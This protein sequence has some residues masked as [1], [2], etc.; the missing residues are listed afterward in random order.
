MSQIVDEINAILLK[1]GIAEVISDRDVTVTD[2]TVS[3]YVKPVHRLSNC[4]TEH[5]WPSVSCATVYHFTSREA[6]E[7]ILNS[8][9]FRFNNIAKRYTEGEVIAFCKSHSLSGYLENG[10][11]GVPRYKTLLMPS[12]F[13]SAFTE[14]TLD[15]EE[16]DY[17]W[18]NF[19]AVDGVRLT[20]QIEASNPNFRRMLY[21]KV[22][23]SPIPVLAELAATILSK[24][25][26][27]LVVSGISRLCAFYL[28]G[29]DYGKEKEY[30][31]L[32]KTWDG[33]G[34]LPIGRGL[35][36]Y[37]EIPL[38]K[39]NDTGYRLDVIDVCSNSRPDMPSDY[40]FT[41]RRK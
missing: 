8:R 2:Q 20:M 13:Y 34:P 22:E 1:H 27:H 3:D 24:Y 28:P 17:F 37:V 25:Q 30:R 29:K 14:L 36:S 35:G 12:M 41:T 7:G 31:L 21:E 38:G 39:M 19:A 15:E 9:K 26:K 33:I 5:L 16:Q 6:A 11:D 40:G 23:G 4:I 32:C 18:R 10:P